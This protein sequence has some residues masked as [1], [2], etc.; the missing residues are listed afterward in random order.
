MAYNRW[1]RRCEFSEATGH[2][3]LDVRYTSEELLLFT[4]GGTFVLYHEQ[5]CCEHV[6]LDQTSG[7]TTTCLGEQIVSAGY[8]SSEGGDTEWG[9][10]TWTFYRVETNSMSLD[11]K[12]HGSSNGYYSESVS[13][14][15]FL[16]NEVNP[17]NYVQMT[18]DYDG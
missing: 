14:C 8:V 2:K 16:P 17:L 13:C 11:I 3:L 15:K 1:D 18:E 6:V 5:D 12:F 9:T 10:E 7:F 4:D